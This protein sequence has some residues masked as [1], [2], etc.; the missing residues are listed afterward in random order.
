MKNLCFLWRLLF[1][2][3][4]YWH[5]EFLKNQTFGQRFIIFEKLRY[6]GRLLLKLLLHFIEYR[7]DQLNSKYTKSSKIQ[8]FE[9]PSL[10]K[11]LP[12]KFEVFL[13]SHHKIAFLLNFC[14]I[15]RKPSFNG[16]YFQTSRIS[17]D[18]FNENA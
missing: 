3:K 5:L 2:K 14:E 7:L 15:E 17:D 9:G 10:M 12:K 16:Q 11:C 6:R 13:S 1:W 4:N 8:Y 18:W